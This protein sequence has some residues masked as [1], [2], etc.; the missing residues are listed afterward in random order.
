MV[1]EVF[2]L[3]IGEQRIMTS[4][5]P[6]TADDK[7]WMTQALELATQAASVGEVPVGA[8]VVR[9]GVCI[10]EGYNQP[11]TTHDPSAHAEMVALRVAARAIGNYRLVNCTLYVTLEPCPMCFGAMIHARIARL[12]VGAVDSRSGAAGGRVDLTEPGLFNHDIH[13]ESGLMAEASSTLL[14]S[15][16][17]QRRKLQRATQQKAREAAQAVDAQRESEHK[18]NVGKLD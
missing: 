3:R 10:G 8:V 16:F 18:S 1:T 14:R 12:V 6:W 4:L 17:Q 2:R 15:F 11:I 13:Y 5:N 7:R 9:D